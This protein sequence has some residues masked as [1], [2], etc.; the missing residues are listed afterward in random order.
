ME[1][2]NP[3]DLRPHPRIKDFPRWQRDD[4]H[5]LGFVDDIRE[6]G[7]QHALLITHGNIVVDGE[8]RRQGAI[9]AGLEDVPVEF[10][11]ENQVYTVIMRELAHRRNLTKGATAY[12][13]VSTGLLDRI[14]EEAQERQTARLKK[15]QISVVDSIDNGTLDRIAS[16]L[17]LC[18]DLIFQA[19]K[20]AKIFAE[21]DAYRID[22]EPKVK[23]GEVGLGAVI[24]GYAG[25]KTTAGVDRIDRPTEKLF[26]QG[27]QT[28]IL[29]AS[30][31]PD[32]QQMR[33]VIRQEV[34]LVEPDALGLVEE[35]AQTIKLCVSQRRKTLGTE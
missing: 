26:H 25:R 1:R 22:L 24:A 28:L 23:A 6:N 11:D 7:V 32:R 16:E 2:R 14:F 3:H 34:D 15:G 21:D 4:P 17:G 18:R 29:R 13:A 33:V 19:R 35:V 10:V 8:T 12:V 31:F 30:R 5:W 9:A 20:V 27:F